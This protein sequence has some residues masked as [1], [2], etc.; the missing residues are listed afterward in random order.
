MVWECRRGIPFEMK[1]TGATGVLE[2]FY[3]RA[4]AVRDV[5]INYNGNIRGKTDGITYDRR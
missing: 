5:K 3:L 2:E 4:K 1:Q